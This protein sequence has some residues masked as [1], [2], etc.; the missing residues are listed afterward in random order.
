MKIYFVRHGESTSDIENKYGGKYDDELTDK[1]KEQAS[2]LAKK[3]KGKN[4]KYIFTSPLKRAET[5][6]EIIGKELG[7]EAH[8]VENLRE[9]NQYGPLSGLTKEEA[10]EQF[11][12]EVLKL[13]KHPYNTFVTGSE[14]YKKFVDRLLPSIDKILWEFDDGDILMVTHGGPIRVIIRE[15]VKSGEIDGT[16]DCMLVEVEKDESNYKLISIEGA[17]I[18]DMSSHE[19]KNEVK[20]EVKEEPVKEENIEEEKIEETPKVEVEDDKKEESKDKEVKAEEKEE[21]EEKKEE[22]NDSDEEE[23]KKDVVLEENKEVKEET[24]NENK[25]ETSNSEKN[26]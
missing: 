24:T 5:T 15:L 9:R 18:K 1:G 21:V 25:E 13:E 22:Q 6:A 20:E 8:I 2:E 17:N 12:E 23:K 7:I 10:K 4:I 11:P 3:L 14:Y 19:Q 26:E 16:S